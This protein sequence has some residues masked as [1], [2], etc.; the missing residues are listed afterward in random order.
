MTDLETVAAALERLPPGGV[1]VLCTLMRVEGSAYR[2][3]GAR[4]LV[5]PDDATVGA[6]SG[7]C[8]EHDLVAHAAKVRASL[9]ATH[10]AYDLTAEDD[11]PWGLNM[12]CR[13]RLDLLL[14]P[15]AAG[16][17][18][19]WLAAALAAARA[20]EP[21][22]VATVFRAPA[23]L[24]A[25]GTRF[26]V[27][28]D[29]RALDAPPGPLGDALRVDA[30]RVLREER[31]DAVAHDLPGGA[32]AAL[33]EYLAPPVA[34]VA[35]GDGPD[36]SVLVRLADALGWHGRRVGKDDE[37]GVMDERTAAVVMTHN[38]GRDRALV[39]TLLRSHARYVGILGPRARTAQILEDLATD[40]AA[41]DAA[42]RLKL[43]APV[44]LDIGA[45]TPEEVALA[46]LAEVRAVL[47]GRGGGRLRER[48]G[49]I[50]DRR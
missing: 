35:F 4:M 39:A 45:E 19:A 32:A 41:P 26:L 6:V 34:V 14:E 13:A 36:A 22:V 15:L 24:A 47:S 11:A 25:P 17:P 49:P 38:Y 5:L 9:A 40:G 30:Q 12:G 33:V 10:I 37:P 21:L 8:L 43:A 23:G 2:G 50:H 28:G 44:G 48:A 29:G 20:R 42:R 27:T 46:I 7:G 31:S 1:A 16:T 3:P 18:P